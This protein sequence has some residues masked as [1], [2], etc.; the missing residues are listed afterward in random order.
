MQVEEAASGEVTAT[1][2][3]PGDFFVESVDKTLTSVCL[4][5]RV[6]SFLKGVSFHKWYHRSISG[7]AMSW[8]SC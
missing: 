8:S 2:S 4:H 7:T 6:N 5:T 1:D 3:S